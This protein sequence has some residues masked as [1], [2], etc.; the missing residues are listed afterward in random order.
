MLR[1]MVPT[2]SCPWWIALACFA[3][4]CGSGTNAAD[5]GGALDGESELLDSDA[6][7]WA[8]VDVEPDAFEVPVEGLDGAADTAT[9]AGADVAEDDGGEPETEADVPEA[10]ADVPEVEPPFAFV[11][12]ADPHVTG[13]GENADRLAAAVA[14]IN[15]HVV[16][17]AVE[18]VVVLGD[19]A[20][21]AGFPA[22]RELLDALVVPWVPVLGDNEVHGGDEAEFPTAFAGALARDAA[23]FDGFRQAPVPCTHPGRG[24]EWLHNLAFDHRGIH[25]VVLDWNLRWDEGIGGETGDLHDHTG[26]TLPWLRDA[27]G[28]LGAGRDG[29]IVLLSHVPMHI[30][31]M[32]LLEL[33]TLDRLLRPFAS[34]IHANLAGHVHATYA[35]PAGSYEVL[36][37]DATWDDENTL[38]LVRVTPTPTA[39]EYAHELLVVP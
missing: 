22:A 23:A 34:R 27:L 37:T 12:L 6:E 39:F 28:A 31:A 14:W 7:A 25:F 3:A 21:D 32:G 16:S 33:N 1:V 29:D 2:P 24:E 35:L 19:I 30:G 11:V 9:D 18:L 36:V 13:P 5:D 26:G 15:A 38:R 20:W 4:A 17:D 10:E 8:D